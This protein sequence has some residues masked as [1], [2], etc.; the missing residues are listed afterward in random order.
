M[1]TP[2]GKPAINSDQN[3]WVEYR[4]LVLAELE[5]LSAAV[6]KGEAN[7]SHV[8]MAMA[9]ALSDAKQVILDKLRDSINKNDDETAKIVKD[10]IADFD[11]KTAVLEAR[12][13]HDLKEV[14]ESLGRDEKKL[15]ETHTELTAL[16]AKAMMLGALS[17]F[18]VALIG[19][20]ASIFI[21]K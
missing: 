12:F 20:V 7:G 19:L 21:K 4:R 2:T 18:L 17:G 15:D 11:R 8:Q 1:S 5:R 6:A 9:Q 14:K 13:A 10:L 16:K 3:G